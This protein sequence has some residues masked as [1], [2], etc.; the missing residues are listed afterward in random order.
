MIVIVDDKIVVKLNTEFNIP[1]SSMIYGRMEE[2]TNHWVKINNGVRKLPYLTFFHTIGF[3]ETKQVERV[4]IVDGTEN[5]NIRFSL[6]NLNFT[7]ELVGDSVLDQINHMRKYMFWANE[8]PFI[9]ID[10]AL[11]TGKEWKFK[12]DFEDPEDNSDLE[13]QEESGRIVRTA[14]NFKVETYLTDVNVISQGLITNAL[15]NIHLYSGI[16]DQFTEKIATV[17]AIGS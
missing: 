12:V 9:A 16:I 2:A 13:A 17:E 6:I 10:D 15:G 4:D 5:K 14:F 8:T 3:H 11:K 7:V 1:L